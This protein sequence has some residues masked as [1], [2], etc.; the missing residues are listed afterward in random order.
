MS[1][2]KP[3]AVKDNTPQDLTQKAPQQ[4]PAEPPE[5]S[6]TRKMAEFIRFGKSILWGNVEARRQLEDAGLCLTP[7]RFYNEIPTLE[8]IYNGFEHTESEPYAF[9]F[10]NRDIMRDTIEKLLPFAEEFEPPI[11]DEGGF[12]W[13]NPAFSFSDAMAYYCFVRLYRPKTILEIG[14]GFSTRVA[15]LARLVNGDT[16]ISC[17][18][19][20]PMDFLKEMDVHIYEE[21]VQKYS[22]EFFNDTLNDGD[23]LFIDSTH[24]VKLSSDCCHL[25]LRILPKIRR[26]LLVHVHD[27]RLPSSVDTR[28]ATEKHIYW[29]EQ[30]LLSAYLLDNPK[31]NVLFGSMAAYLWLLPELERLMGGKS[32]AYGGSFWFELKGRNAVR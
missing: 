25:Y 22:A 29:T 28:D 27:I 17:I 5:G 16:K 15:D 1:D 6:G 10:L 21:F 3:I 8:E 30:H 7:A 20:Y 4:K 9:D 13:G 32:K 11:E 19:P 26:N 12:Y 24:T 18:E 2:Q 14:S 23:L 31:I